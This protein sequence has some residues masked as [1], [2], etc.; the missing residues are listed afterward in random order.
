M[1]RII[2]LAT[3]SALVAFSSARAQNTREATAAEVPL[4]PHFCWAQFSNARGPQFSMPPKKLCGSGTNH[5]CSGLANLLRAKRNIS[6]SAKNRSANLNRAK[7]RTLYT[8]KA[9]ERYPNCPIRGHVQ[10]TLM[11]IEALERIY[12]K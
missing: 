6:D 7:S 3:L 9:L 10:S 4:L 1:T 11:E 12:V 8:V 5:Y 2:I